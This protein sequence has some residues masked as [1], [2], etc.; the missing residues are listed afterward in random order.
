MH[1]QSVIKGEQ[2]FDCYDVFMLC[3]WVEFNFNKFYFIFNSSTNEYDFHNAWFVFWTSKNNWI[4]LNLAWGSNS[5]LTSEDISP[6]HG[7]SVHNRPKLDPIHSYTLFLYIHFNV[8]IPCLTVSSVLI[9]CGFYTKTL[10][11]FFNLPHANCMP[12]PANF[13]LIAFIAIISCEMCELVIISSL[14]LL[15]LP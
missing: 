12:C 6:F 1:V 9:T 10:Y 8:M 13:I 2:Y 7:T 5:R 3:L 4:E 11:V 15:P 14:L